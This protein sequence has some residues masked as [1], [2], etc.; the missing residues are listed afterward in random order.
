MDKPIRDIPKEK[1][2]SFVSKQKVWEKLKIRELLA[3][4]KTEEE[5]KAQFP[6]MTDR[7]FDNRMNDIR[8]ED[9]AYIKRKLDENNTFL[10]VDLRT[11]DKQLGEAINFCN[12]LI[13]NEKTSPFLKLEAK[14]FMI[15]VAVWRFKLQI[16]GP[17]VIMDATT[18]VRKVA[19]G[20][21]KPI[22]AIQQNLPRLKSATNEEREK[23]KKWAAQV[24]GESLIPTEASQEEK[25]Q[26]SA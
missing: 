17:R 18:P 3:E 25:G 26:D 23:Y 16:E 21:L 5:I 14:K 2:K 8:L 10:V 20:E 12:E 9:S 1:R 4:G 15:D 22:E 7:T 19:H 6:T 11:L 13:K 24:Q